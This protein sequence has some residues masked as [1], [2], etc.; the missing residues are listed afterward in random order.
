MIV[1]IICHGLPNV[2]SEQANC[3]PFLYL[4]EFKKRKILVNI[5]S[6]YEERYNSS[7]IKKDEQKKN[8][9]K[10]FNNIKEIIIIDVKINS[11]YKKIYFFLLRLFFST[12]HNFYIDNETYSS[13]H[14]KIKN[15]ESDFFINFYELP[16]SLMHLER[17]KIIFNIFGIYRKKSEILRI[18]NLIKFSFF[19]NFFKIVNCILFIIKIDLVYRKIS[20]NSKL[21]FAPG[22]DTYQYLKKI[23][24]K[25]IIYSKPLSKDLSF[26][27]KKKNSIPTILLIGNL[28]SNIM[29][30]SLNQLAYKMID[31]LKKIHDT[32]KFKIRIVGKFKPN[33]TVKEKLNYNWIKFVGWVKD[34][35]KEY[36][37]ADYLF[38]PNSFSLSPRTKIIEAMSCGTVVIASKQNI[39]GIFQKMKAEKNIIIAKNPNDFCRKFQLIVNN[40]R[41]QKKISFNARK[42]YKK[43]YDP[44]AIIN[45]NIDIMLNKIKSH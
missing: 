42:T 22:Y 18:K 8:L 16:S 20:I 27:N 29:K 31:Q 5:I 4:E 45:D 19:K 41:K 26:I 34:S 1:T 13:F 17:E 37:K 39:N 33:N 35:N 44:V 38:A 12:P 32:V 7:N 43:Y 15:I 21:N 28:G 3:D 11:I 30:D 23:G 14:E 36:S 40:K 6:I 24:I 25:N 10:K 9:I 2:H